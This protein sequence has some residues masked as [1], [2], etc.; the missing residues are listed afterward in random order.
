MKLVTY[1]PYYTTRWNPWADL[2]DITTNPSVNI[3]EKDN[4]FY[5][6]LVSPGLSKDDFKIELKNKQLTISAEKKN[7]TE[8]KEDGKVWRK[9]Y[10][11]NSFKRSFFLPE[12]V[13]GNAIE[14]NYEQ[15]VLK[16]YIPKKAEVVPAVKTI[17]V[18]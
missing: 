18:S 5:L 1:N 13:E 8:T 12:T 10:S 7:E 11:F 16:V 14:A 6:D 9:E 15:G 4:G 2:E 3:V 17:A